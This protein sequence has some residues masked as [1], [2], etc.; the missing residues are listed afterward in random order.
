MLLSPS[1]IKI[2]THREIVL[3]Q[4]EATKVGTEEVTQPEDAFSKGAKLNKLRCY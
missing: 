2:S 4:W 3:E 1:H